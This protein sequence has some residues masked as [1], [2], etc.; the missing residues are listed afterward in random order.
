MPLILTTSITSFFDCNIV[1]GGAIDLSVIGGI[2]PY[3]YSWSNGAKTEDLSKIPAGDYLVTVTDSVGCSKTGE[4]T[5]VRPSSI[6]VDVIP[7]IEYCNSDTVKGIYTAV[8][9]G[10]VP[11]YD[12]DWS[13]GTTSGDYN[14]IMETVLSGTVILS[15]IDS[16]NCSAIKTFQTKIPKLGISDSLLNCN[17]RKYQFKALVANEGLEVY[18]YKWDFGDSTSSTLKEPEH[19]F[20]TE[21]IYK[22]L[23]TVTNLTDTCVSE[24]IQNVDVEPKPTVKIEGEKEFCEGE[25]ITLKATGAH[26]YNWTHG[27]PKTDTTLITE[28]GV[29]AVTGSTKAGCTNTDS[30]SVSFFAPFV[31]RIESDKEEVTL[32]DRK[33]IFSTKYTPDTYYLWDFGDD[34][35]KLEG[36]DLSNPPPHQFNI[37][38][39][40]NFDVKLTVTNPNLCIEE[41]SV[42]IGVNLISIP[43]TFTPNGDGKNDF[44]LEGWNKKI[45]NRNGV[46]IFEGVDGW[47]GNYKG[48]PVANDTYFVVVYDSA[49]TGSTPITSFIT[50]FTEKYNY[51]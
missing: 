28:E 6:T 35:P 13:T 23:L 39:D 25:S 21:G 37:N 18:S 31:Y 11:P 17:Q 44:Y 15:V 49:K 8:V 32:E 2:P 16:S 4:Y 29:Y 1:N 50:V 45:F 27:G 26:T 7:K 46:L 5:I 9:S 24:Y 51:K 33:V 36:I 19:I 41:D 40:G 34:T 12:L 10:G 43:N 20:A 22:V 30:Y 47:D 3:K 14:E 42:E 38:G 48:K